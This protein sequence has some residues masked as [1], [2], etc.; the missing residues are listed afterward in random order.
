VKGTSHVASVAAG[1]AFDMREIHSDAARNTALTT[2]WC[3]S[4]TERQVKEYNG[5]KKEKETKK[6]RE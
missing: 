3:N 6:K 1:P 4:K 5:M 2:W